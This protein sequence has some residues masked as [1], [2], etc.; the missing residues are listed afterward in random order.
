MRPAVAVSSRPV[1]VERVVEAGGGKRP[2][3][4]LIE[5]GGGRKLTTSDAAAEFDQA[6]QETD[7][8]EVLVDPAGTDACRHHDGGR[9][10]D[11]RACGRSGR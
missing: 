11:R 1:A 3:R 9:G 5:A 4:R 7:D 10:D 8:T 2:G 6:R